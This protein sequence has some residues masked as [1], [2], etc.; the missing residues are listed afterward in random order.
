[1]RSATVQRREAERRTVDLPRSQVPVVD[2]HDVPDGFLPTEV[3]GWLLLRKT[4]LG[5]QERAAILSAT[6]GETR[7]SD[8]SEKLR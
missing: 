5:L 1:M 6:S 3:R 4:K 7:V 8:V 2:P